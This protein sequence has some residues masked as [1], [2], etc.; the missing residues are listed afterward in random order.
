VYT[1]GLKI[2]TAM[3]PKIQEIMEEYYSDTKNFYSSDEGETPQSSMIIIDPNNGDILGVVGAI[4]EKNAN[5]IQNFATQTLRPP[6]S[7]IKPVSV[8]APALEK[9]LISW[10]SVYDDV[11]V[12]FGD[13]IKEPVPWPKNSNNVYRG[14]TN[15]NYAIKQSINTVT[16]KVLDDV[17]LEE[18][19]D[20]L[21]NKVGMRSL[22][23]VGQDNNGGYITDMDYAALALGQLN[24]G[25]TVKEMTAAYTI[26]GNKGI[27]SS[28]RSYYKVTDSYGSIILEN[29]YHG[30]AVISEEN[31]SIMTMMLENVISDGTAKTIT[32]KNSIDC[33]GKTGTTQNNYDR[34]FIGYTPN[35][36]GGVWYGYEYPRAIGGTNICINVWD[37]IMTE[38]YE[39]KQ[40]SVTDFKYSENIIEREYCADSGLLLTESCRRDPRGNRAEKGYFTLDT[41]PKEY[42]NCHVP[43][44]YDKINGGISLCKMCDS[45]K[46]EYIGLITVDRSFPMQIYVTDA[47]YV[48]KD[49]GDSILPETSPALPFF[50]NIFNEGIYCGI[51]NSDQQFNRLCRNHFNYNEWLD[52]RNKK[53]H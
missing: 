30:N 24:Y 20:F 32:L 18:S 51:T 37:D 35:Y 27:Y 50:N 42:C 52:K 19:F 2:Y 4:G 53:Y 7:V 14:L 40:H 28:P 1:G 48:W 49:I 45:D 29:K 15:I 6:G 17:G 47:Q 43:V 34:W 41:E 21:Y 12:N 9:N 16:V 46:V 36:I 39:E 26:F 25:V 3:D 10:S 31:S 23:R 22:I 5:R 13:E 11:P 38:I 8:Y 33:A 44:S